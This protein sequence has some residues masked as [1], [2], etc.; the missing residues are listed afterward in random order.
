M[1]ILLV[2]LIII[3]ILILDCE[4]TFY[5]VN[6]PS[7]L[8]VQ[9]FSQKIRFH[10]LITTILTWMVQFF[11]VTIDNEVYYSFHNWAPSAGIFLNLEPPQKFSCFTISWSL[12]SFVFLFPLLS[13]FLLQKIKKKKFCRP[14]TDNQKVVTPDA[15]FTLF[16]MLIYTFLLFSFILFF[17]FFY[18]FI[19][20][21]ELIL[22]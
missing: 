14:S 2:S 15:L 18:I 9:F 11:F 12:I 7:A 4:L 8:A 3:L 17:I 21:I 5:L 13:A 20:T 6:P 16:G 19:F 1:N 22:N 10:N